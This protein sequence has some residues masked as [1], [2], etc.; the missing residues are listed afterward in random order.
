MNYQHQINDYDIG[1]ASHSPMPPHQNMY[2]SYLAFL[3]GIQPLS[4]Q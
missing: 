3:V 4:P 2:W 1:F